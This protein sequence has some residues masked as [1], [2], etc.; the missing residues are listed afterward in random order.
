MAGWLL[1]VITTKNEWRKMSPPQECGVVLFPSATRNRKGTESS[2]RQT[3]V[4]FRPRRMPSTAVL[5]VGDDL[6][7][8]TIRR[9]ILEALGYRVFT[10]D[11]GQQAL[12]CL[13][14]E[15]VDAVVRDHAMLGMDG[16]ETARRLRRALGHIP[17]ILSS[18]C[19]SVPPR[20]PRHCQFPCG[21]GCWLPGAI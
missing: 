10:A 3:H 20:S 8:L 2:F 18:V 4:R 11:S 7:T 5:L 15:S 9:R 19:F 12:E 14:I 21:K 13:G 6:S 1:P 16:E 17:I